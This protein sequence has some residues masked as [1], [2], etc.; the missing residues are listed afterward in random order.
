MDN[1]N[2]GF[3]PQAEEISDKELKRLRRQ[4]RRAGSGRIAA[5]CVCCALFGSVLSGAVFYGLSLAERNNN[6][7]PSVTEPAPSNDP[8]P[9]DLTEEPAA[10]T[11]NDGAAAPS[12]DKTPASSPEPTKPPA[13]STDAE[14]LASAPA[15]GAKSATD[16]YYDCAPGVVGITTELTASVNIFGQVSTAT[17]SGTGFIV[18]ADGYVLTNAHV[19]EGATSVTVTELDGTCHQAEIIG[20]DADYEVGVLKIEP[21][22]DLPV[23]ELGS[24][25]NVLVGQ[26]IY[27]IGNPLG[28]LTYSLT[29]GI[30]SAMDRYINIDGTAINAFQISA[31]V[32]TGNSGGPVFDDQGRVIGLVT[33]KKSGV[34]VEGLGFAIT[35]DDA[36]NVANDLIVKGYVTGKPYLGVYYSDI[37][38]AIVSYYNLPRGVYVE[39]VEP[40]CCAEKAGVIPGDI[41]VALDEHDTPDSESLLSAK[42]RY[43]AGDTV[44]ITVFRA[45]ENITLQVTL[46]EEPFDAVH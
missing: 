36:V 41:I 24:I 21:E 10:D 5:L 40:G 44:S 35:V 14:G 27:V 11:A 45:G 16:I 15:Q 8:A 17:V 6:A 13:A 26:E 25:E 3:E 32:N 2:R 39:R 30:V 12:A 9:P 1:E 37:D 34:G 20:Y 29:P 23:L 19:I 43:S 4:R 42:K 33:A 46:D 38:S 31:A 28:E 22:E 7:V 18:S